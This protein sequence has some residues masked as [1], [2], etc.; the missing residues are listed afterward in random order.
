MTLWP[1]EILGLGDRFG[2]IET[3]KI[4]NL[5]VT[6]GSPLEITTQIEHLV[7]NGRE[8]STDNFHQR[9]YEKYRAR[10]LPATP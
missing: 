9:L 2:S 1:A 3:G 6:D 4:A 7:I 10:P 5:I 8:V